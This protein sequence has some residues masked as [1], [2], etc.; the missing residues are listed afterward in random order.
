MHDTNII[1]KRGM[2]RSP[3]TLTLR[4]VRAV[5]TQRE[6]TGRVIIVTVAER[7]REKERREKRAE[8]REKREEKRDKREREKERKREREKERKRERERERERREKEKEKTTTTVVWHAENPSVCRFKNASVC[9][10]KTPPCVPR[11]RAHVLNNTHTTHTH[12]C[13]DTYTAGNRP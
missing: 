2:D 11:K 1:A 7:G 12:E 8:R 5:C 10:F 3:R 4:Q 13:L 9:A 6:P